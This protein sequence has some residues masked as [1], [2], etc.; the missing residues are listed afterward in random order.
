MTLR[1][2]SRFAS[3]IKSSLIYFQNIVDIFQ[4]KHLI[5]NDCSKRKSII[6]IIFLFEWGIIFAINMTNEDNEPYLYASALALMLHQCLWPTSRLLFFVPRIY[7]F[8]RKIGRILSVPWWKSSFDYLCPP[9]NYS[10][11]ECCHTQKLFQ[12]I[13]MINK[14]I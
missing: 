9:S 13:P 14:Q 7:V 4:I 11:D 3:K 5:Q 10:C 12:V 1:S 8:P 6:T 2:K